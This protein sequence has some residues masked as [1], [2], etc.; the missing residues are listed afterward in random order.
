MESGW[1][2]SSAS[3]SNEPSG[4]SGAQYG[5]QLRLGVS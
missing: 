4:G 2:N 3:S 5:S 1:V